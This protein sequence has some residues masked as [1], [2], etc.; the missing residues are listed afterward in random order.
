LVT[1]SLVV[2]GLK[3][4][5]QSQ[6]YYWIR[7]LYKVGSHWVTLN[8]LV[9]CQRRQHEPNGIHNRKTFPL[10]IIPKLK[11][12]FFRPGCVVQWTSHPP[13]EHTTRFESRQVIG[14]KENRYKA[15]VYNRLNMHC[16][17]VYLRNKGL[18]KKLIVFCGSDHRFFSSPP[19]PL[20]FKN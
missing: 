8:N 15:V 2:F 6:Y 12:V 17:C 9:T 11:F 3:Y 14:F 13:Q 20:N 18:R 19:R 10:K 1:F 5:C 16:L 7:L 4:V